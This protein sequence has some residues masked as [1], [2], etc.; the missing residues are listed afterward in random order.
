MLKLNIA[1]GTII[2]TQTQDTTTA[3]PQQVAPIP[4]YQYPIQPPQKPVEI[5]LDEAISRGD[6]TVMPEFQA[7]QAVAESPV[8]DSKQYRES[9]RGRAQTPG[10]EPRKRPPLAEEDEETDEENDSIIDYDGSESESSSPPLFKVEINDKSLPM[11]PKKRSSQE[12]DGEAVETGSFA[13]TGSP[14]KRLRV[15]GAYSPARVATPPLTPSRMRK[16]SSEELEDGN[17]NN[18]SSPTGDA[19]RLKSSDPSTERLDRIRAITAEAKLR[20]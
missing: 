14:P 3:Q 12:L 1:N 4:T 17:E 8:K 11:T 2:P 7:D 15:D 10:P 13:R 5:Q 18:R 9:F 19:K 20:I 6:L 16:R